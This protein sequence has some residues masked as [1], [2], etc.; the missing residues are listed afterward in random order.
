MIL[1]QAEIQEINKINSEI[2]NY[3]GIL[4]TDLEHEILNDLVTELTISEE[5]PTLRRIWTPEFDNE[6]VDIETWLKD[7]EFLGDIRDEIYP[8]LIDDLI[9]LFT[10]DYHECVLTGALGW[11]KSTF[12]E[13]GILRQVYEVS[14]YSNPQNSFGLMSGSTIAIFVTFARV[15]SRRTGTR[16]IS[17][18]PHGG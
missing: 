4:E 9:E 10:G 16:S 3:A 1:S 2:G 18:R 8:Q 5:S 7:R 12:A 14:C 17:G 11:G 13:V 6:I 15:S